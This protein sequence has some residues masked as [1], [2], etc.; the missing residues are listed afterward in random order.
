MA[1][2]TK[3]SV[4]I[5]SG[6]GAAGSTKAVP[7]VVGVWI[8]VTAYN[9]GLLGGRIKNNGAVGVGG[10]LTWQWSPDPTAGAPKIYDLYEFGGGLAANSDITAS[11]RLDKEIK[12][13]RAIGW[14]NTTSTVD[15]ESTLAAGN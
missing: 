11:V 14:G 2:V 10:T 1:A 3:T 4:A 8:D 13:V 7:G 5:A 15:F 9:G 12:F 6:T